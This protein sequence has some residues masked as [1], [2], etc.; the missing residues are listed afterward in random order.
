MIKNKTQ[1]IA[2]E[3]INGS[4][5]IG[6]LDGN[7]FTNIRASDISIMMK[8]S[9]TLM[10]F[11]EINLKYAPLYLLKKH[12]KIRS[13]IIDHPNFKLTQQRDSTWNISHLI[14]ETEKK[15]DVQN[16]NP[17]GFVAIL[18]KLIINQGT[19]SIQANNNIIP[20]N[21]Y[22][23]NLKINGSYSASRLSASLTNFSFNS[24]N[25]DFEL[26]SLKF[27]L[28]S[29]L[30]QWGINDFKMIT[31]LNTLNFNGEYSNPETFKANLEWENIH[32]KEFVFA[33]PN[34][35]IPQ[36]PQLLFNTSLSKDDLNLTVELTHQNESFNLKGSIYNFNNL[37]YDSL[38]HQ[39]NL[40][41][42]LEF[43]NF[44]PNNWLNLDTIPLLLNTKLKITGNGLSTSSQPLVISG[45]FNN[46]KWEKYLVD[47]GS[48]KILYVNGNTDALIDL[49][50]EMGQ[51]STSFK[52]DLNSPHNHF[53]SQI[54]T[55]N[56]ALHKIVP[57]LLDS[58]VINLSFQ[59]KGQGLGTDKPE[60]QF[61]GKFWETTAEY[62]LLDSL[63]L[64][65]NYKNEQLTI[66]TLN[67]SNQSLRSG[68]K[69]IYHK[70]GYLDI[71]A[72][73]DIFNTQSLEYYFSQPTSWKQLSF[74]SKAEGQ[75]DSLVFFVSTKLN[76]L[77]LDNT[78]ALDNL[79]LLVKG[80]LI[81]KQPNIDF[82]FAANNIKAGN[83]E[84]DSLLIDGNLKD[85]KWQTNINTYLPQ[86]LELLLSASGNIG[87]NIKSKLS[88]FNINSPHANF[89]L[90][91]D[92]ALICY[93]DSLISLSNFYLE[94]EN[95]SLFV[96][97]TYG[98]LQIPDTLKLNTD[99]ENLNLE[100]LSLFGITNQTMK[101]IANLA[102][103]IE[104]NKNNFAIYGDASMKEIEMQPFAISKINARFNYPG[105]SATLKA[106][107]HNM[108]GDSITIDGNTPLNVQ[109]SDSIVINWAKTF[110]AKIKTTKTNLNGFF[111]KIPGVDQPKA[112]L[113][114]DINAGGQAN[115]PQFKGYVD[116]TNGELPLPDY[117]IDYKDIRLKLSIDG[118]EI[119]MDSLFIKHLKGSLLA[120]GT[121]TIDSS[122]LNGA[123][124]STNM[125]INARDFFISRHQN[126]EIQIN[127]DAFFN[128]ENNNPNFGG[129][130][131][132]LRSNFNLPAI[133][134]I[135]NKK[136]A[137]NEP[138]LVK[139]LKEEIIANQI[140]QTDSSVNIE[141]KT[142]EPS[143]LIDNLTGT[144]RLDVPRNTWIRSPDMQMELYGNLDI[145]KN[146]K[147]FELFGSLGIHR[148]YYTLYGKKLVIKQGELIFTGGTTLNPTL[149]LE[150]DYTFRDKE[151]IKR[152]LTLSVKG[153]AANPEINFMLDEISIPE[154]D[155]M[156]YLLFG[157]AFD[158]LNYSNQEG[159]SSAIP[160]RLITGFVSSQ[161]SKT[162]GS[163]L[164]LDMIE[165][166]AGNNWQNTTFIMGKYITNDLFVT[167]ERSFGEA[168]NEAI[169]PETIT[170]EYELNRLLSI[171][172]VQGEIKESGID[173]IIKF[174]K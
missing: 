156:A 38:R 139:S 160:S 169:S 114:I 95:D 117:G 36:N 170:L 20:K 152:I 7:F 86:K 100:L 171:R 33:L 57:D 115:N 2:N 118:T 134:K 106:V 49:Q 71:E 76:E 112:L 172:L 166:D 91:T 30:R 16:T 50:S 136:E 174:E 167:Y 157:H 165:I 68:L 59:I 64:S 99:I 151:K 4:L 54:K 120:Q 18:D 45:I 9:D 143:P 31:R 92:T 101:G 83:Q 119:K 78:L 147:V 35:V 89:H 13:I 66:D 11:N 84:V 155:A 123:I 168:N 149:N 63:L 60:A 52:F 142:K 111:L 96:F 26:K 141:I 15:E 104:G 153:T 28:V 108:A 127:A 103:N 121:M 44:K 8:D 34:L 129:K 3:Y 145:L 24:K 5:C 61:Y 73:G 146:S 128:D 74:N 17:F 82:N 140:I 43:K 23:I 46:T 107:I 163:T 79:K 124:T 56:L 138:L 87:D 148:G 39:T 40:D 29:D 137:M 51:I 131:T 41:L 97:K 77:K 109:L 70:S 159:V 88:R 135:S 94:D 144:I 102:L 90:S 113:T 122:L 133:I 55:K 1:E 80:I 22:A 93:N 105:D 48:M 72:R 37:I 47:K 67:L 126:H 81:N 25:P 27:K 173:V 158:D 164:N 6:K 110:N 32:S 42:L 58:T 19:I 132:V 161:L 162:I 116:I 125:T 98:V 130:I 14:K 75:S 65:G 69:G 53:N 85:D 154:A 12:I 21:I 62:I 150:A 10:T